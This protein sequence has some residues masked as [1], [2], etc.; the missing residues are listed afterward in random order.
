MY[1]AGSQWR[2]WDPHVHTP[3]TV[4]NNQFGSWE[5]YLLEIER[6]DD[7]VALGVTDYM[8]ITNYSK[9][10]S[11]KNAGRIPNIALLICNIEFRIAPPT[12]KATAV[13]I[14]LLISP[15]DPE[16][17][18]EILNALARL[19]W[20]YNERRYSCVPDQ[21]RGLGRAFDHRIKEDDPALRTGVLQFKVDFTRFREWY[22]A[23]P[24]LKR[25]SVVAVSA[26]EDGLSAFRRDGAWVAH[27]DEITRFSQ[28]IFSGRPGE[29]DFWLSRGSLEDRETVKRL[30]GPKPCLHGSDAHEIAKLFK[31]DNNRFCW[32]KA[33]PTFEGLR[34]VLFEPGDRVHIGPSPPMF[35]DQA[36]VISAVRISNGNGWFDDIS[37]PLNP[38]LISIIG[39]KGSGKSA[40]AELVSYAAGSWHEGEAGSFLGRAGNHLEGLSRDVP[41]ISGTYSGLRSHLTVR[42]EDN[43]GEELVG[44]IESVIF[45]NIDPSDTLNASNLQEVRAIRTES[46]MAE[47]E[48]LHQEVIDLI[49]EESQL[50]EDMQKLPEK[51][52]R[53]KTLTDE[54]DGLIKQMPKPVSGEEERVLKELQEKRTV[55]NTAQQAAAADKQQLQK[56]KDIRSR[57]ATFQAQ[58]ARCHSE[59]ETSLKEIGIPQPEFGRFRPQFPL[60]T[61][62]PL[63][64]RES[65]LKQFLYQRDG[66]PNNPA[67]GTIRWLQS[68]IRIL[69]EKESTDKARQERVKLIQT[70]LAAIAAEVE[71]LHAEIALTEG[72]GK[73]RLAQA[74]RE[75]VDAYVSYFRNLQRERQTLEELYSPM[76]TKLTASEQE[77]DLEFSIQ[78]DAE[79]GKWLE[80]GG[81]LFDQRK[82]IPY[83]TME[84]LA[85]AARR[86]LAPAWTSGDPEKIG[87]AHGQF[88][89]EF[90]KTELKPRSYLRTGVSLQDLIQWLYEIDHIHLR[91]GLKY[92][93]VELGKLSPGTKGI[94]LLILYLGLDVADSRPLVVDQPDENL[95]NESIYK[96]LTAYFKKAKSRRQ[97]ILI[98]HNPNLVVNADSEQVIVASCERRQDGLP[99]ITYRSGAL[100]NVT[101]EETAIRPL[102]CRILEGGAEA[103]LKRERRYSLVLQD[104]R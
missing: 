59:I 11:F 1:T 2:R 99:H 87:Q 75:R 96:L 36:R 18:R 101:P 73:E 17:E 55:L 35:H 86:I 51:K 19:D 91:Y 79:I 44:E 37:V 8:S 3:D 103:F 92:N 14:H 34:Q 82:T 77:Q 28:I 25:N 4:L 104:V 50:N 13:N 78:W 53:I 10:R 54:R 64:R 43:I 47:G 81:V 72:P 83:G 100:E 20:K 24:W 63:A 60:D 23:E 93:G 32:I 85:M 12:E 102:A 5:Q 65:E 70:R 61:E 56:I 66:D 76:K 49:R 57:I 89:D 95:D 42:S 7:I 67:E 38:G 68:Q 16:H 48:R 74:Y 15:D 26:G 45:S 94:V 84:E 21:L 22:E 71:R 80:R 9:L 30:G 27:R 97:I 69:S 88:L 90:R 46:I 31:P 58:M 52:L 62:A 29:R 41:R 39:Q 33:D 98:T 40:L 6:H